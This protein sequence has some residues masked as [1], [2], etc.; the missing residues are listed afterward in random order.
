MS[1][2]HAERA[3]T[4]LPPADAARHSGAAGA[5][6]ATL[7]IAGGFVFLWAFL[8]KTFGL[9]YATPGERAWV[10]GGSP[11]RGF[12]SSVDVGPFQDAFHA[13]AGAWWADLLF[14]A[15]MAGVGIAVLAG[16]AL[17]ASAVA[18]GLMMALM[19]LA[20]FP[21]A[22]VA[23]DGTATGST[24]PIVDYHVVYALV[25]IVLALTPA[26]ETWGLGRWWNALPLVRRHP[27]T[28]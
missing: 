1:I 11:T 24:N 15:G 12:L 9:G 25:L 4:P 27:W 7:R 22:Q 14:M 3:A 18:G 16:V 23:A 17:R 21:L 26:G 19:W 2:Q 6:L 5:A 10:N 8:D 28:R 20:E 13:I